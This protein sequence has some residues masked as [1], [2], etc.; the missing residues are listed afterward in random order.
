VLRYR[1]HHGDDDLLLFA[2]HYDNE[3]G[4]ASAEIQN[5]VSRQLETAQGIA[6]VPRVYHYDPQLQV[7]FQQAWS[8]EPI[9]KGD[10]QRPRQQWT[11]LLRATRALHAV[12]VPRANLATLDSRALLFKIRKDVAD[13]T[14]LLPQLRGFMEN[15]QAKLTRTLERET[16]HHTGFLHGSLLPSQILLGEKA[17]AFIDFDGTAVGDPLYDICEL[18]TSF[19]FEDWRLG[20]SAQQVRR[21]WKQALD[22]YEHIYEHETSR[23][24]ASAYTLTFL[25]NRTHQHLKKLRP[26]PESG[27]EGLMELLQN[28][29]AE[30]N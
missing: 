23:T 22:E 12:T 5:H 13:V 15:T 27:L 30:D 16:P 21:F 28:F 24:L 2:K 20:N 7:T 4:R 26:F 17:V 8:G 11:R 1:L 10:T 18:L 6:V 14:A 25:L 3:Q 19:L 9:A 29:L